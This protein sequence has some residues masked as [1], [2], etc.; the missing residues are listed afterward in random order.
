[1]LGELPR[2]TSSVSL[3]TNA[4]Q[5]RPNEHDTAALTSQFWPWHLSNLVS[6]PNGFVA[7]PSRPALKTMAADNAFADIYFLPELISHTRDFVDRA[8]ILTSL[9]RA[10]RRAVVS[11][12]ITACCPAHRTLA[13]PNRSGNDSRP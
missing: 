6:P 11:F 5:K 8:H 9:D 4:V 7:Q 10:A 2:G 1:M 12:G 13:G 3:S